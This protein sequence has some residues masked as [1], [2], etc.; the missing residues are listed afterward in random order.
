MQARHRDE[1][2]AAL[3]LE[4]NQNL[5]GNEGRLAM[6]VFSDP[7]VKEARRVLTDQQ[8]YRSKLAIR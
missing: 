4:I 3:L 1:V 6:G 8:A 7:V 5:G 2:F